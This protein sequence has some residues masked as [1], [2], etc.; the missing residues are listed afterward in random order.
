MW[1]TIALML[2]G[3]VIGLITALV[4]EK[5][6][7]MRIVNHYIPEFAKGILIRFDKMLTGND[8]CYS[9]SRFLN[10]LWGVGGFCLVTYCTIM[11]IKIEDNVLFLIGG[12]M[13]ISATQQVFGKIQEVKQALS[14]LTQSST[15]GDTKNV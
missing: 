10:I 7:T 15:T 5:I 4:I 2:T 8:G 6:L 14:S 1:N 9:H 13:T 3:F 11:A 12:A